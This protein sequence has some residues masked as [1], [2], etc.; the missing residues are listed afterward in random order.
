M[1]DLKDFP[2]AVELTP[3]EMNAI[4]FNTGRHSP[5]ADSVKR[6]G[7]ST[8]PTPGKSTEIPKSKGKLN[9]RDLK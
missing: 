5:L 1:I 9:L 8:I 4:H 2:G 7:S 6:P 3:I